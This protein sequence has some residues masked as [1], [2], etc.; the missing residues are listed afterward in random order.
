VQRNGT[1]SES[2]QDSQWTKPGHSESHRDKTAGSI[3]KKMTKVIF[4][5]S[6]EWV[7]AKRSSGCSEGRTARKNRRPPSAAQGIQEELS[8]MASVS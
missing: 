1:A 8:P 3:R 6:D 7:D 4:A 5:G 2:Q